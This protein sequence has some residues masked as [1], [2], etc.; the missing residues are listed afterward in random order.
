MLYHNSIINEK[1]RA[2]ARA[3]QT[4]GANATVAKCRSVQEMTVNGRGT[5]RAEFPIHQGR[6]SGAFVR[7]EAEIKPKGPLRMKKLEL[8]MEGKR[9]DLLTSDMKGQVIDAEFRDI[10]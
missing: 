7:A 5:I 1:L 10:S 9:I 8:H 3:T 6:V 2:Q 4:L